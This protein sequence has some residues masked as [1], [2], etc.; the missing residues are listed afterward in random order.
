MLRPVDPIAP[1]SARDKLGDQARAAPL[2]E[3][4]I[5]QRTRAIYRRMISA[6]PRIDTNDFSSLAAADLEMLFQ[7][8]D[9]WFFDGCLA[10]VL[11]EEGSSIA[12]RVS[13]RMT[14]A[15][16]K[17]SHLRPAGGG[18]RFTISISSALL[19]Q[20]FG[21]VQRT[22]RVAGL[23]CADR[24]ETLQLIFEHE[25]IHL[26]EMLLWERSKCST[27]R[28]GDLARGRFGHTAN[29]H[30]LVTQVEVAR[31]VHGIKPGDRVSFTCEGLRLSGTVNR[32]VRRATVLVED[33]RGQRYSDGKRYAKYYVPLADL[34]RD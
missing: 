7:A 1:T 20:T 11:D 9:R 2:A 6:S 27:A 19:F 18:D 3:E 4:E 14:R 17:T 24:L 12:F 10:A 30:E 28:F 22:V 16:G 31:E 23:V 33:R 34:S 15:G 26:L 8:Y 13:S 32:I 25:L 21:R 29:S 5:R